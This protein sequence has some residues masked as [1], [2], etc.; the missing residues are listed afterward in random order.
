MRGPERLA[1]MTSLRW[2]AS[3]GPGGFPAGSGGCAGGFADPG[4]ILDLTQQHVRAEGRLFRVRTLPDW[5]RE[6][7][8]HD[9]G[10]RPGRLM[11][12]PT[13]PLA[14]LLAAFADITPA[15][16]TVEPPPPTDSQRPQDR[17]RSGP[18][19]AR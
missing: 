17:R 3:W 13:S 16:L 4:M 10:M 15:P 11:A 5:E 18:Q 1:D 8:A 12:W 6:Q 19:D 9:L 2:H 7:A 14:V